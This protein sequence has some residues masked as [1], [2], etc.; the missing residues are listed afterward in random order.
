M[1]SL[2]RSRRDPRLQP[3]SRQPALQAQQ[4]AQPA[5]AAEPDEQGPALGVDDTSGN[6]YKGHSPEVEEEAWRCSH[7]S[8]TWTTGDW[9]RHHIT[10]A[11]L[12][13]ACWRFA[14]EH[15]GQLPDKSVLER[16][17]QLRQM[18][19]CIGPR[20]C[21]ECGS[22]DSRSRRSYAKGRWHRHPANPAQ[23]LCSPCGDR[24][25]YKFRRQMQL[26]AAGHQT[27][28][29]DARD[30]QQFDSQAVLLAPNSAQVQ[31]PQDVPQPSSPATLLNGSA[32]RR[33]RS[34]QG[35][36][37]H[38]SKR[39]RQAAPASVRA[40]PDQRSSQHAA[41]IAPEASQQEQPA[42]IHAPQQPQRQPALQLSLTE[43]PIVP[44]QAAPPLAPKPALQQPSHCDFFKDAM[45]Q[46]AAAAAAGLTAETASGF[47]GLLPVQ[48]VTVRC[49]LLGC[50]AGCECCKHS[51]CPIAVPN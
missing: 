11:R 24:I 38:S 18:P 37:P 20:Q 3:P 39:Q 46:P 23:W 9:R 44:S 19:P 47:L 33:K 30:G 29:I 15:A 35:P 25:R 32:G 22:S 1:P 34:G 10:R 21:V 49:R 17:E 50:H 14:Y 42:R 5:G 6:Q 51:K 43:V 27:S 4:A 28:P 16:R 36:Q 2:G 45:Q 40:Q 12:C 48:A 7:C 8:C 41:P 26:N 13:R 31:Q